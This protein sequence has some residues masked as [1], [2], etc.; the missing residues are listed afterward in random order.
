[1]I[2]AI[3][4]CGYALLVEQTTSKESTTAREGAGT[5]LSA[6]REVADTWPCAAGLVE[7]L[8]ARLA[9]QIDCEAP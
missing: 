2:K 5:C 7:D 3:H 1:M 9:Q 8:E 4:T 6:L